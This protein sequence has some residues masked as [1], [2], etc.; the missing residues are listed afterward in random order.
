MFR[1]LLVPGRVGEDELPARG[2]E[3]PVGHVDGDALFAFRLQ[4][5]GEQREIDRACAAIAGRGLHR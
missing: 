4:P 2:R 3:A 5:V 1:V